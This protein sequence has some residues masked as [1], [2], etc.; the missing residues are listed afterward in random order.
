M[1]YNRAMTS[2]IF[3]DVIERAGRWPEDRQE[4]A[5]R[6]LA[7]M[8]EQHAAIYHLT[9]EQVAE[10]ERRRANPHRKF[11]TLEEVRNYFAQRRA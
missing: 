5:A 3:K 9:D 10:V 4:A 11:L 8:E 6:V 7:D 1:W 2:R